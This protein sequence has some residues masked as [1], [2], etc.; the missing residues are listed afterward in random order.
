MN[1]A[2]DLQP[3]ASISHMRGMGRYTA[4][5]LEEIFR[6]D[7]E[8]E[9]FLFNMYGDCIYDG[10]DLPSNVHYEKFYMGEDNYLL[11]YQDDNG[12]FKIR[13][14]TILQ[15]MFQTFIKRNNID[16]FWITS[17]FD[18]WMCYKKEWFTGVK[19]AIIAYD[20][21]PLIFQTAY[22]QG[23]RKEWYDTNL[24][25]LKNADCLLA[26]SNSVKDDLI[27]YAGSPEEKITV[28][29]SGVSSGFYKKE[30]TKEQQR[31]VFRKYGIT[32][33][34]MIFPSGQDWRKNAD[35]TIIG[36]SKMPQE[37]I[38][39]YQ[40]VITGSAAD[41]YKEKMNQFC[42]EYGVEGRVIFTGHIPYEDLL[43]L[44]NYAELVVF[45]SLYEGF[46]LP[47]VEAYICG[48]NVLTSNNS[49]LGEV[50]NGAAVL[51]DPFDADDI[52][53][54]FVDAL[55]KTDFSIFQD[56]IER[57]LGLYTWE[58]S[59]KKALTAINALKPKVNLPFSKKEERKKIAFFTPL[60]PIQSGISDYSEGLIDE[61]CKHC[62]IDVFIDDGYRA[63][64]KFADN[65]NIY[66]YHVF[67]T[68]RYQYADV[69]YQMGNS[70]FHIY[71]LPYIKNYPGT[72]EIHDMNMHHCLYY[73]Y[74]MAQNWDAYKAYLGCEVDDIDRLVALLQADFSLAEYAI[75]EITANRFVADYAKRIIVH[76]DY[77]R[78]ELLNKNI[79]YQVKKINLY[80]D[81]EANPDRAG[82][83]QKY[84][85]SENEIVIAS[86]GHATV[87]KRISQSIAALKELVELFPNIKYYIVGKVH[88]FE[89]VDSI[90]EY[91]MEDHVAVTGF[92]DAKTFD[93]YI[94][95]ADICLNLRYP[96]HGETSASFMRLLAAGKP[97]IVTDIGAFSEV[98]DHCCVKIEC[99]KECEVTE[100]VN[101][102]KRLLENPTFAEDIGRNARDFALKNLD[103]KKIV[104]EYYMYIISEP[105]IYLTEEELDQIY[106]QELCPRG[107]TTKKDL[108]KISKTLSYLISPDTEI[109]AAND[110]EGLVDK[111]SADAIMNEIYAELS[112]EGVIVRRED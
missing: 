35:G 29:H 108:D 104:K 101:S 52:A 36:Y 93:D 33:R 58:K 107:L 95:I 12:D 46:G 6:R 32:S 57:K 42:A 51:V 17:L 75:T 68:K 2:V 87:P 3:L 31:T 98:P 84:Q 39:Q 96:Y 72:V 103:I 8:N 13:Y 48:K 23:V 73:V 15:G 92:V 66:N 61:L 4:D 94:N 110:S 78:L 18:D 62:D 24:E 26:I 71:M 80:A 112:K 97:T 88:S 1:I 28:I 11:R 100:I 40:L 76:S 85:I 43:L 65:V 111:I 47:I 64:K 90:R 56:E 45:P 67:E 102:V 60:N 19:L 70:T 55:T 74:A 41:E 99:D 49:S 54:G 83:R 91:G 44:Y 77:G 22:L 37:L 21:I 82:L 27:T 38:D 81:F 69:V 50:A 86:F 59:A 25:C 7:Q 105:E 34:F 109:A 106:E 10:V 20:L 16:V 30:F 14:E 5:L 63:T 89:I 79:E 53:R 9:Y